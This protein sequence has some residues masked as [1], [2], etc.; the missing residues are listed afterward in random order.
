[1]GEERCH[2]LS[3]ASSRLPCLELILDQPY[4]DMCA[5]LCDAIATMHHDDRGASS[6]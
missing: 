1:M 6:G 2:F 4:C 5:M 3:A